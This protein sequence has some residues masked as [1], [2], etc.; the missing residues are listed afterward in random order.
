MKTVAMKD[1]TRYPSSLRYRLTEVFTKSGML[2]YPWDP[3]LIT[4]SIFFARDSG[5]LTVWYLYF[6]LVILCYFQ[7]LM[8]KKSLYYY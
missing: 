3:L 5:R 8:V 4:S 6:L 7:P 1:Q 2:V